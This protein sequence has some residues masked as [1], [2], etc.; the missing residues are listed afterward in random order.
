MVELDYYVVLDTSTK[1]HMHIIF[2]VSL[3]VTVL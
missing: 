3:K 2:I 1:L